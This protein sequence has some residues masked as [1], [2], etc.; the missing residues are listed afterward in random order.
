MIYYNLKIAEIIQ[1]TNDIR[2]YYLQEGETEG[3]ES[4]AHMHIGL[5]GFD[6]QEPPNKEL[7]R[8][9]SISTLPEEKRIGFTT[10]IP[11]NASLF[12]QTLGALTIGSEVTVFKIGSRMKLRRG[13]TNLV[14]LSMGVG[15]AALR[16]LIHTFVQNPDDIAS[17]VSIHIS[18]PAE[19]LFRNELES[20]NAKNLSFIWLDGRDGLREHLV[21]PLQKEN[22]VFYLVGSD[23]FLRETIDFLLSENVAKEDIIL[24]KKDEKKELFFSGSLILH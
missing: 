21:N 23:A 18:K 5:P 20:L 6:S 7:V 17:L 16:P 19:H 3:W 13:N 2:T 9:M 15:I 4:G 14:F 22:T 11:V 10:R 8:H 24:D 12:K 1:N